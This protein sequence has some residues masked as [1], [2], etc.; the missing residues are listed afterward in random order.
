MLIL[1]FIIGQLLSKNF[2]F[3]VAFSFLATMVVIGRFNIKNSIF[4]EL[5][6]SIKRF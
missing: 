1:K 4:Q 5:I 2:W 3:L 6:K